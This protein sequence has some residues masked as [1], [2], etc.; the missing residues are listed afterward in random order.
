MEPD[1]SFDRS[2]DLNSSLQMKITVQRGLLD[3]RPE[4]DAEVYQLEQ[5][6]KELENYAKVV[7]RQWNVEALK[8]PLCDSRGKA[9]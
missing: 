1:R 4:C 5:V 6:L 7:L 9:N 2:V 3:L 8:I